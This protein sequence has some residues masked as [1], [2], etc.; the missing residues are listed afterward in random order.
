M[1]CVLLCAVYLH[2]YCACNAIPNKW[3]IVMTLAI[4]MAGD[5]NINHH[6]YSSCLSRKRCSYVSSCWPHGV[7]CRIEGMQ[8]SGCRPAIASCFSWASIPIVAA[9]RLSGM[10]GI[11]SG[12]SSFLST[13]LPPSTSFIFDREVGPGGRPCLPET[14]S[15]GDPGRHAC[16]PGLPYLFTCCDDECGSSGGVIH[17]RRATILPPRP[18]S[19][20][21]QPRRSS[22]GLLLVR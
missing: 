18:C 20:T 19:I 11:R 1:R 2:C 22:V 3:V 4:I 10:P 17:H 5:S 14:L 9:D 12:L 8:A 16:L 13:P 6:V 21:V 15:A 7:A